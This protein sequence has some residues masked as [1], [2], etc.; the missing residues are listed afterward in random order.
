[1]SSISNQPL[2]G[3]RSSYCRSFKLF[4]GL[5]GHDVIWSLSHV[6]L[7]YA[8]QTPK[9]SFR[10]T[11]PELWRPHSSITVQSIAAAPTFAK[12]MKSLGDRFSG[13]DQRTGLI[14]PA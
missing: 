10:S 13:P 6:S 14:F 8:F 4:V 3:S 11:S 9:S 2:D 1:I 12:L 7:R 5:D